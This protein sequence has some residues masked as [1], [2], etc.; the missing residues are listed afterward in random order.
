MAQAVVVLVSLVFIYRQIRAQ[1]LANSLAALKALDDRW[2]SEPYLAARREIADSYPTT[3]KSLEN[4]EYL[5][6]SFFEEVGFYVAK[7]VFEL[8]AVWEF[9]SYHLEHYWPILSQKIAEL[10]AQENDQTYYTSAESL[11]KAFCKL[12]KKNG[13]V[14]IK[15]EAQLQKFVS[16]EVKAGGPH[17][18]S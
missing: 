10:R 14:P 17:G 13:G 9:Y 16:G 15:T 5:V 6:L 2:R 8:E 7:G 4:S 12:S 11:Y 1:R 18:H 3:D